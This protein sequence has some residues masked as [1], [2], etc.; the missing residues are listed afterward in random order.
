MIEIVLN[1]ETKTFDNPL[2]VA[3]VLSLLDL[4]SNFV[5]IEINKNVLRRLDWSTTY[6]KDGDKI[7]VIHFVGGG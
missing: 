7:E 1:G 3:D 5:A 6:L 4:S 2:P